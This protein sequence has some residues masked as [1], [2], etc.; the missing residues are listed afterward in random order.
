MLAMMMPD[1]KKKNIFTFP[2]DCT[3][4]HNT[5]YYS[6]DAL[7]DPGIDFMFRKCFLFLFIIW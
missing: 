1:K 3:D 5:V 7:H 6:T 4:P 2:V